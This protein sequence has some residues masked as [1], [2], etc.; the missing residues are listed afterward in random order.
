MASGNS[1]TKSIVLLVLSVLLLG[2][3]VGVGIRID[4]GSPA[5]LEELSPVI[6][7]EGISGFIRL[8]DMDAIY[9]DVGGQAQKQAIKTRK[10]LYERA[11]KLLVAAA[12]D[13][14]E[15]NVLDEKTARAC[16]ELDL[17][18]YEQ[19]L[20]ARG[21]V[22]GSEGFAAETAQSRF[23]TEHLSPSLLKLIKTRNMSP[24]RVAELLFA[25]VR[26]GSLGVDAIV[27]AIPAESRDN[28]A[29]A[30]AKAGDPTELLMLFSETGNVSIV[31][32]S[33]ILITAEVW[34]DLQQTVN[35][36]MELTIPLYD[37]S[38]E[39]IGDYNVPVV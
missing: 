6:N 21:D 33:D 28:M 29:E 5:D 35:E 10:R 38:G 32:Q 19:E 27:A 12:N 22:L 9:G 23:L 15:A 2:A 20:L 17:E 11:A 16:I 13:C 7:H 39:I 18:A 31:K 36:K 4:T 14:F 30:Q 34:R 8:S 25:S 37:R 24:G 1:H 3:A 26:K